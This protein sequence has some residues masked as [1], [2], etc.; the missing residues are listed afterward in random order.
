MDIKKLEGGYVF[1]L[2]I[3][4]EYEAYTLLKWLAENDPDFPKDRPAKIGGASWLD[5]YSIVWFDAARKYA[6]AHPEQYDWVKGY[7]N[8]FSFIWNN[9]V[10]G[11]KDCDYVFVPTPMHKFVEEYR[12]AGHTAKFLG[13][14]VQVAFLGMIDIS[15]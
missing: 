6:E 3:T 14:D 10:E 9:E 4:P 13:S 8:E 15:G 2:G 1:S 5:G 11:L 7:L 12:L